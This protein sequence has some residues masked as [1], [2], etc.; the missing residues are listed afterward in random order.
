MDIRSWYILRMLMNCSDIGMGKLQ[1]RLMQGIA[2]ITTTTYDCVTMYNNGS[3][4]WFEVV[5]GD[6]VMLRVP[7]LLDLLLYHQ[8]SQNCRLVSA[9]IGV[10]KWR[11]LYEDR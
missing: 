9:G 8:A 6:M 4:F 10:S 3:I 7:K 5:W 2:Y 11:G 1:F